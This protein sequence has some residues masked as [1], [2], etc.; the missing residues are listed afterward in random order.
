MCHGEKDLIASSGYE[1]KTQE[2]KTG[3]SSTRP[4]LYCNLDACIHEGST[5]DPELRIAANE[6][7]IAK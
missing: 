5:P 3:N 2:Q 7:A 6:K 4:L 1:D